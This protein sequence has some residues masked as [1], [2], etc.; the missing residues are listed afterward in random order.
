MLQAAYQCMSLGYWYDVGMNN[1][2]MLPDY[3]KAWCV[4][5]TAIHSSNFTDGMVLKTM[6][7]T[8]KLT[9]GKKHM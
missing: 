1:P 9:L 3:I 6:H 4:L 2:E 7:P 5:G 8:V